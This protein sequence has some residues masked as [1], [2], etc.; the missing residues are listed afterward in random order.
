MADGKENVGGGFASDVTA[1]LVVFLVA[2]PLCLGVAM[3]SGAPLFSGLLAGVIGGIVVGALSGSHTSVSGPSPGVAAVVAA[4]IAFLNSYEAFF[5][6]VVV[7]GFI[8]LAM[9]V[10]R[11]G[12]IAEFFP[13]SVIKGL[14]A[15][16]GVIL[17]LKQI[18]HAF[19]H[20]PDPDGE[21]SFFQTDNQNTFSEIFA[22]VDDLNWS[23]TAIGVASLLAL[24][25]WNNISRLK[26]SQIPSAI[27]V[28]LLG[29]ALGELFQWWNDD[30]AVGESHL[31]QVPVT[32]SYA[33]LFGLLSSPDFSA[34]LNAATWRAGL[35]LALVGS[36]ETLLN[37]EAVDK[38]DPYARTSPPNRELMAQGVGNMISG[39]IGGLLITSVIVRSS[40][41]I[42]AGSRT[43]W[44]AIM[45]GVMILGCVTF[46][47]GWLNKIPLSCLAA[48]LLV[49]G[50]KLANPRRFVSMW[51]KGYGQFLPFAITVVA[52][53]F[54]DLLIGV[55]IGLAVALGFILWS[56]YRR[57]I[58]R[59]V[60]KHIGGEVLHVRLA[61]QVS[62]FN[63]AA[64]HRTLDQVPAGGHVLID[65]RETNY[66]DGDVLD[67]IQEYQEKTAP[68]RGIKVS[69][70]GFHERYQIVDRIQYVDYSTRD[71]QRSLTPSQALTI[72]KE[73]HERFIN[74]QRL[75]RNLSRQIGNTAE[76][77]FPFAVVLSCI[78]SR[79]PAEFI[80]DVG[81]GDIFSIRI[82]GNVAI[83]KVLGS[84]EYACAV[85]GA[86]LVVVMGHSRCG[87]VTAAVDLAFAHATASETTGCTNLD[88]IVGEIQ[89]SFIPGALPNSALEK[90]ALVEDVCERNILRA[91]DVIRDQSPC[92][93]G[94]ER[95]GR[96][97][98]VGAKYDVA[99]GKIHF[100]TA[101]ASAAKAG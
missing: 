62:F 96:I 1:G 19:G 99:T 68:S 30:W 17:I 70:N 72:L 31:V 75:P 87:A 42:N 88:G 38:I 80:F 86:K 28:V 12:F 65:A 63:R 69:L 52:I 46:L 56:N 14:L 95:E 101:D 53:V 85:A 18:P 47:P 36:L 44:S 91:L 22:I 90:A 2:L 54:T 27:V 89:K 78:D 35:M 57:P 4:Q 8:Q 15:A 83:H 74:D 29:V 32:S 21:M 59:I 24:I 5:A 92:L 64:I 43:R 37:L 23:A 3:A 9:G 20:D 10:G 100:L 82:A 76:G 16:I 97:G 39:M 79:T 6:A 7:A 60:E 55:L 33:E 94:L 77:Q 84:M 13:S 51:K 50:Y 25:V 67:L 81:V 40:I 48:I 71:L 11:L 73:G 34:W 93:A 58:Q 41:N 49:T 45:H 26:K 61:N 66:I 98:L